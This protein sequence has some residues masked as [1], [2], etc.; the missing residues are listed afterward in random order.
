[1]W[2]KKHDHHTTHPPPKKKQKHALTFA[3]EKT[4]TTSN[5]LTEVQILDWP[6]GVVKR[7]WVGSSNPEIVSN[8]V[9]KR[10]KWWRFLQDKVI[11]FNFTFI[12]RE[13]GDGYPLKNW[14]GNKLE[15][16]MALYGGNGGVFSAFCCMK[17]LEICKLGIHKVGMNSTFQGILSLWFIRPWLLG[18]FLFGHEERYLKGTHLLGPLV[19]RLCIDLRPVGFS[20]KYICFFWRWDMSNSG[21][22]VFLSICLGGASCKR[23]HHRRKR[24]DRDGKQRG[25]GATWTCERQPHPPKFDGPE[26][27]TEPPPRG[28]RDSE[29]G[30]FFDFR[31]MYIDSLFE[32][33]FLIGG[34]NSGL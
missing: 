21:E 20:S 29:L 11:W 16:F 24:L 14:D 5:Q 30:G 17:S 33:R 22:A 10:S 8:T 28:R 31:F 18:H 15:G 7:L 19:N 12:R 27:W 6:D 1:M 32:G 2:T 34:W 3:G 25:K 26:K 4:N 23:F 9:L 13:L